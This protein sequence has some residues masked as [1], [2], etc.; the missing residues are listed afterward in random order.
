MNYPENTIIE[1]N[2]H[3]INF[4]NDIKDIQAVEKKINKWINRGI[5]IGTALTPLNLQIEKWN[6]KMDTLLSNFKNNILLLKDIDDRIKNEQISKIE[7]LD[8]FPDN[9]EKWNHLFDVYKSVLENLKQDTIILY[10]IEEHI[11]KYNKLG[12]ELGDAITKINNQNNNIINTINNSMLELKK[13]I[14]EVKLESGKISDDNVDEIIQNKYWAFYEKI[15]VDSESFSIYLDKSYWNSQ[16][17]GIDILNHTQLNY[18]NRRSVIYNS[19]IGEVQVHSNPQN[20]IK[21][22]Y[23]GHSKDQLIKLNIRENQWGSYYVDS[24]NCMIQVYF[25][26]TQIME[27]GHNSRKYFGEI[28]KQ[29]NN[30]DYQNGA[31]TKEK[32]F[33]LVS[34]DEI[35]NFDQ[36]DFK[37]E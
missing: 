19:S 21:Y 4:D 33:L 24:G 36:I 29:Q 3:V 14:E 5:D 27:N 31:T 6:N 16:D 11:K 1:L 34:C 35:I 25:G 37:G 30:E 23:Y 20:P 28:Y 2:K 18:I 12:V 7:D 17:D 10:D 13:L 32:W 9:L 15:N 8:I 26:S 22:I